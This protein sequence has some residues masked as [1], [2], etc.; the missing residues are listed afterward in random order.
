MQIHSLTARSVPRHFREGLRMGLSPAP[1]SII[2]LPLSRQASQG[3]VSPGSEPEQALTIVYD[4]ERQDVVPYPEA[5]R[6]R[7]PS[8]EHSGIPARPMKVVPSARKSND[9]Y[10]SDDSTSSWSSAQQQQPYSRRQLV[11]QQ[12][13]VVRKNRAKNSVPSANTATSSR[14]RIP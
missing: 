7:I 14:V 9:D 5:E 10:T 4:S 8:P 6:V 3:A 12:Q 13:A 1:D 2:K 11:Q